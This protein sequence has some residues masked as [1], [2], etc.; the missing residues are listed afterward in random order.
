M[1]NTVLCLTNAELPAL[2]RNAV[3]EL[4][5]AVGR[6]QQERTR[7][8]R[9]VREA[10]KATQDEE[11]KAQRARYE[12][13]AAKQELEALRKELALL[14]AARTN[15]AVATQLQRDF[16]FDL[17]RELTNRDIVV[18]SLDDGR[19]PNRLMAF[20]TYDGKLTLGGPMTIPDDKLL[21]Q[22]DEQ[23]TVLLDTIDR[24]LAKRRKVREFKITPSPRY[25]KCVVRRE[26]HHCVTE[27]VGR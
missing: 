20:S 3:T 24:W 2:L 18:R 15:V 7:T 26:P 12:A 8:E 17:V 25:G 19:T 9:A 22:H 4:T 10:A 11:A 14:K 27:Q 1:T 6:A 21:V 16:L 13:A 23:L 5:N